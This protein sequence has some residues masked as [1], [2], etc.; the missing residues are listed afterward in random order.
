MRHCTTKT[1]SQRKRVNF[2]QLDKVKR[3]RNLFSYVEEESRDGREP[4]NVD[5]GQGIWKVTL[6]GAHEEQSRR[7]KRAEED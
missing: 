2:F 4:L 7:S 6:A 5:H 1:R 3:C